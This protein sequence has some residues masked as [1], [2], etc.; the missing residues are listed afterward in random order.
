MAGITVTFWGICT[1][2]TAQKR[3]VLVN[4]SADVIAKN[5]KLSG[6]DPHFAQLHIRL[7]DIINV[8]PLPVDNAPGTGEL[9][10]ALNQVALSI[11]NPAPPQTLV[12]ET[13]C[14][15]HLQTFGTI[16]ADLFQGNSVLAAS[17]DVNVAQGTLATYR[18][19]TPDGACV[20]IL[21]AETDGNPVISIAPFDHST[22]SSITLRDGASVLIT[23]LPDPNAGGADHD[24]DF[25]LHFLIIDAIP[26]DATFPQGANYSDCPINLNVE[27]GGID[28][29]VGPGCSNSNYP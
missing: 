7:E 13:G 19:G 8:G 25:L 26:P 10:F 20:N 22:P 23:N 28:M 1:Y 18:K 17:F 15:L 21:S 9:R 16:G 27:N 14:A 11:A 29:Y 2:I 5:P 12:E 24:N 3:F 6:I 4:A